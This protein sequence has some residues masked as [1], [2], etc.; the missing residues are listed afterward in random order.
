LAYLL[1]TFFSLLSPAFADAAADAFFRATRR[2]MHAM[3]LI[4]RGFVADR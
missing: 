4:T 3:L 1:I 2:A